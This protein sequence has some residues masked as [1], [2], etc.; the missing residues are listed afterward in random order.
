MEV[1]R[2]SQLVGT[3]AVHRDVLQDYQGP[4][5]LGVTQLAD[6]AAALM[7]SVPTTD[8]EMFPRVVDVGGEPVEVI[9]QGGWKPPVPL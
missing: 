3:P 6:R 8:T 2:L 1:E 5:A 7:L 9:V 4:Y